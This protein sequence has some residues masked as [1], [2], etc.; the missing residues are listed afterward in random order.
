MAGIETF[1]FLGVSFMAIASN[2]VSI[3]A[4]SIWMVG[5]YALVPGLIVF[6]FGGVLGFVY[7]KCQV[8]I[9]REMRSVF[10]HLLHH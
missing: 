10:H 4:V 9:R 2:F 8:S 6:A 1:S 7:L 3:Y 5:F